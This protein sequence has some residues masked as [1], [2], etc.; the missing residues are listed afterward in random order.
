MAYVI[1]LQEFVNVTLVMSAVLVI[2]R[3]AHVKVLM[4]HKVLYYQMVV[5]LMLLFAVAEEFAY[6]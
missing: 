3:K 6:Q 5:T 1:E 2:K 4:D